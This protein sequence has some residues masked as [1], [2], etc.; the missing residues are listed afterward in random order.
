MR[1]IVSAHYS[2]GVLSLLSIKEVIFSLHL[3]V[4][5]GHEITSNPWKVEM[6]YILLCRRGEKPPCFSSLSLPLQK[7]VSVWDNKATRVNHP[8]PPELP[9][10]WQVSPFHRQFIRTRCKFFCLKLANWF[11]RWGCSVIAV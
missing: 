8:G 2:L 10:L 11:W 1:N 4:R 7:W 9:D 6:Q 5:W 3:T